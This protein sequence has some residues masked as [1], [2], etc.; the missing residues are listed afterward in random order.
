LCLLDAVGITIKNGL[1]MLGV[2]V[3]EQM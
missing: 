2:S 1:T 3:K